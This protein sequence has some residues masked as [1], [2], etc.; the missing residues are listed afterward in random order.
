MAVIGE[1]TEPAATGLPQSVVMA[2]TPASLQSPQQLAEEVSRKR[3]L[4][5]MKNRKAAKECR[6]RKRE[7]VR[8]LETRLTML[9]VQNKKLIDELNYLKEIY[10]GISS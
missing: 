8:C 4:R 3:E 7:Y 10:S 9:E 5:L 2:S 1:E 6:R